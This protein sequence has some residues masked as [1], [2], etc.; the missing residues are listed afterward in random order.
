MVFIIIPVLWGFARLFDACN[1][2][3]DHHCL[4]QN[5]FF[6]E[7]SAKIEV[8]KTHVFRKNHGP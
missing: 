3:S 8:F 1:L 6:G 7:M 2:S 4:L 5:E